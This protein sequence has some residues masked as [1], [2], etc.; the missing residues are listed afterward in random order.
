MARLDACVWLCTARLGLLWQLLWHISRP[1]SVGGSPTAVGGYSGA[2]QANVESLCL[3]ACGT[4]RTAVP[5]SMSKFRCE[6]WAPLD[7][8]GRSGDLGL[9]SGCWV[10]CGSGP[11]PQ[12]AAYP[13]ARARLRCVARHQPNGRPHGPATGCRTWALNGR[14]SLL[15]RSLILNRWPPLL[16]FASLLS[17]FVSAE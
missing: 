4:P 6:P 17:Y 7:A 10:R 12:S 3:P 11:H 16:A 9:H 5:R 8:S 15:R 1:D 14:Q 2:T 13:R